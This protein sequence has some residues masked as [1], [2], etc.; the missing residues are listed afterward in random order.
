MFTGIA[1]RPSQ[2]SRLAPLSSLAV[3]N[4]K[5]M[6][7]DLSEFAVCSIRGTFYFICKVECPPFL[8]AGCQAGGEA[9]EGGADVKLIEVDVQQAE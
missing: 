1:T 2:R 3:A 7:Q 5:R 6:P 4:D 8:D 9:F